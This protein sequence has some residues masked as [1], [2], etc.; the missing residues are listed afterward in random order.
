MMMTRT[1]RTT[2]DREKMS[3]KT[4]CT[5]RGRVDHKT[6]ELM[7]T[8]LLLY[9]VCFPSHRSLPRRSLAVAGREMY[10]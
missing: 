8:G 5:E 7:H 1:T 10:F 4:A 9:M 6:L 3:R 2:K